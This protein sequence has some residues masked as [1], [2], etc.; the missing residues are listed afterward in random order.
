MLLNHYRV[1]WL[2]D[3]LLPTS[4]SKDIEQLVNKFNLEKR[5]IKSCFLFFPIKTNF[6]LTT[7]MQ[8]NSGTKGINHGFALCRKQSKPQCAN[9]RAHQKEVSVDHRRHTHQDTRPCYWGTHQHQ[10]GAWYDVKGHSKDYRWHQE[11]HN[12]WV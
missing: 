8:L 6:I 12:R 9:S 11:V 4:W 2:F 10:A 5:S 1:K 7:F 3:L